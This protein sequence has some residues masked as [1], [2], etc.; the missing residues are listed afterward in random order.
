M[1]YTKIQ[2][3]DHME[4]KVDLYEDQ[5][6]ST[7]PKC[8]KEEPVDTKMII[9]ILSDGGDFSGTSIYCEQ[10]TKEWKVVLK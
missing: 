8:S 9:D 5:I 3:N 7:C 10:C 2:L 1:L 6:F 4:V